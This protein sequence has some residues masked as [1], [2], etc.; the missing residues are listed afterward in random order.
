[1]EDTVFLHV[2]GSQR[3]SQAEEAELCSTGEYHDLKTSTADRWEYT[4]LTT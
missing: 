1:M 4:Y 3:K 2:Q